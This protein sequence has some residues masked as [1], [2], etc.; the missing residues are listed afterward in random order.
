MTNKINI[1]TSDIPK[2]LDGLRIA[3]FSDLHFSKRT[4]RRFLDKI[5]TR[6]KR[7]NADIIVF[8]GD[9]IC[10]SC[11][12]QADRLKE[13]LNRFSAPL[14]CYAVL[15]NHD[16]EKPSFINDKGEYD[17]MGD[18]EESTIVSGFKRL[19]KTTH[20][21]KTYT[22]EAQENKS[23]QELVDVIS[24]TPFKL[25]DN[26]TIQ[27]EFNG[28]KFNLTGLGEYVFKKSDT[29]K[30]FQNY[31]KRYPGII[32]AHNPDAVPNLMKY[33]GDLILSGHTHGFQI[34]IPWMR[35]KFCITENWDLTRGL[36]QLDNKWLYVN[37]GVGAV[38]PFRWFSLPEITQFTLKAHDG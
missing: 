6:V 20:L 17:V 29:V 18:V 9:F 2:E 37:R 36:I 15:G 21:N 16:Y 5:F 34:N 8:T 26:E 31:D 1:T 3:Q 13:F 35:H 19:A 28:S 10:Y 32:L 12:E 24:K 4:S 33:P 22:Q 23:H 27:L 25:M 7:L 38:L 30:A 14:G 11:L